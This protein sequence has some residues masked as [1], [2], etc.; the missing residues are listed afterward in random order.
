[1]CQRVSF[2]LELLLTDLQFEC[3]DALCSGNGLR[4]SGG[5]VLWL[6]LALEPFDNVST[7]TVCVQSC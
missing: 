4:W 5:P 3:A 2:C 1:M 7:C 6:W